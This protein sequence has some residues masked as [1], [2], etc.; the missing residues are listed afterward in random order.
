MQTLG[1][2]EG[3][4]KATRQGEDNTIFS[5]RE[6]ARCFQA[7][8][9]FSWRQIALVIIVV[10]EKELSLKAKAYFE[11]QLFESTEVLYLEMRM[12][13]KFNRILNC[14][15]GGRRKVQVTKFDL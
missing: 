8:I 15:F 6:I 1:E 5:W 10:F 11:K 13:R 14:V 2:G 7:T 4:P 9:F 12:D 3:S